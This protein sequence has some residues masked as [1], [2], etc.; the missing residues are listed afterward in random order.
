MISV[1]LLSARPTTINTNRHSIINIYSVK[2]KTIW[3]K[4][5]NLRDPQEGINNPPFRKTSQ[6]AQASTARLRQANICEINWGECL[7]YFFS[8]VLFEPISPPQLWLTQ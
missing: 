4:A 8:S 3:R 2:F 1:K 5:R 6:D 7:L